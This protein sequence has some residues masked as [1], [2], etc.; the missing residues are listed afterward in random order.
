MKRS[1]FSEGFVPVL[2]YPQVHTVQMI[3]FAANAFP[4]SLRGEEIDAK[5]R[6]E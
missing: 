6:K 4:S 2:I 3:L 5:G 1:I